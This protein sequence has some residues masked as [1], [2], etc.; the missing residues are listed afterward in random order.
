M[1]HGVTVANC[2][3]GRLGQCLHLDPPLQGQPRFDGLAAA[4]GVPDAV[5]VGPLLGDDPA[6]FGQRLTHLDPR[7]EPVHAVELRSGVGDSAL[8][9]H[10]RRH[11]QRVTQSDLEVVRI[12]CRCDF[13]CAGTEFGVDMGVGD[14]DH[15]AVGER[16]RQGLANQVP[17][18][19]VVGMDRDGGVAE[20]GLDAS[21]GH[22]DVR[23]VVVHRAVAERDQFAF[24]ILV[25]DLGSLIAVSSTG[26]QLTN[27]SA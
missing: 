9:I 15:L 19:L 27:R 17:V 5:Q 25:L 18:P 10:D 26:D 14:D 11:R 13:H 24:D 8:G 3:A 4:L 12:V 16:V 1:N 2:I 23:L 6:L 22:D 7:L 21:R 20:H